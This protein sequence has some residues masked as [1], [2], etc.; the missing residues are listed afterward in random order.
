MCGGGVLGGRVLYSRLGSP[1]RW[2]SAAEGYGFYF[3]RR[4]LVF[5]NCG[6]GGVDFIRLVCEVSCG[7]M[8]LPKWVFVIN[9]SLIII[10]INSL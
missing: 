10:H 8:K 1:L 6:L 9:I 4:G 5:E 3:R 2:L 7:S